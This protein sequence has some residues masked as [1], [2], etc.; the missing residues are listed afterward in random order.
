MEK[1]IWIVV[2][3]VAIALVCFWALRSKVPPSTELR[4][5]NGS[6]QVEGQATSDGAERV[7]SGQ[8]LRTIPSKATESEKVKR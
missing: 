2:G 5:T 6:P 7:T 3:I 1:A 8:P 4:R